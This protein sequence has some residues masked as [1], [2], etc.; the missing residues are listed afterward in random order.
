MLIRL[1]ALVEQRQTT[2]Y[3]RLP[4]C[5]HTTVAPNASATTTTKDTSA[6]PD[7]ASTPWTPNSVRTGVIARK[8]GMAALW[9]DQGVRVP[10]TVLQAGWLSFF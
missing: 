1:W 5:I 9:N 4:S 2:L 10:V 3:P 8:R 7:A 6:E